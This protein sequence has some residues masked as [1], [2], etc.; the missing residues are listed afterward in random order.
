MENP[1]IKPE[2]A[3]FKRLCMS[4][5][6]IPTAFQDAM[7][8]YECVLWLIKYLENTIIP[9]VNNN[10][11][12]VAELQELYLELKNYVE[13]MEIQEEVNN[14]LDEMAE[15]GTLANLLLNYAYVSKVY[16]TATDLINDV[17]NLATGMHVKTCG[18]S[19][20]NDGGE[21]NYIISNTVSA[22]A[23][24][25]ALG[26]GLYANL[27]VDNNT[28]NVRQLGIIGD[29]STDYST[30]INKILAFNG[31]NYLKIEFNEGET[32]LLQQEILL[33][34]NTDI[35]LNNA[36]LKSCYDG[37]AT[38]E[39]VVIGNG[40]RFMNNYASLE[41]AGGY[42]ALQNINVIN[43]TIDGDVTG[44]SFFLFHALN[45]EFNNIDFINCCTGTHV[46]DMGCCK[47]IRIINCNFN[48][49]MIAVADNYYREVIQF[50][51]ADRQNTPYW[52]D[53]E[54]YK[55]DGLNCENI[56]VDGCT[57]TKGDGTYYPSGVGTHNTGLNPHNN[58][59]IRNC[60]FYDTSFA[61]IRLPKVTNAVIENN[62][63]Y[64]DL[65]T[66]VTRHT[67]YIRDH[68][69]STYPLT[70]SG[71]ILINN[72]YFATGG[73][74]ECIY[75]HGFNSADP[76][77]T[78]YLENVKITNN[79]VDGGY[80]SVNNA[81]S[82]FIIGGYIKFIDV[83]NNTVNGCKNFFFKTNGTLMNNLSFFEN[84]LNYCDDFIKIFANDT[85]GFENIDVHK[86]NNIF[87]DSRGSI[88]IEN[89]KAKVVISADQSITS[90]SQAYNKIVWDSSDN[91]FV[92]IEAC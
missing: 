25:L 61:S 47:N 62:E 82:H 68:F 1:K 55:Y 4:I 90:S 14:K 65:N 52:G 12:A 59:F 77:I 67:I 64:N 34:S 16:E 69:A 22:N 31:D 84:K 70:K 45:C 80:T 7:D 33:Y 39:Y 78:I 3:P 37:N 58:I 79:V 71:N 86:N 9:V 43:G 44:A 27:I 87:T 66:S 46:F 49:Y 23:L 48:G 10:G 41:K 85:A 75:I 38:S 20:V 6:A 21:A 29:D 17:A 32:Y 8:Y 56:C 11:A 81:D 60:K 24:Q 28:I 76:E 35:V 74:S 19:S 72:N 15:D 40:L 73:T 63:F 51:Y 83:I 5:G 57:F 53:G 91:P 2:I 30:I 13:N 18:Y 54:D 36:T 50:D 42:G 89:F 92:I 88:N 26:S